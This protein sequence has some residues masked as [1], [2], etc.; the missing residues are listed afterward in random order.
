MYEGS[1][2]L[3]MNMDAEAQRRGGAHLHKAS[4]RLRMN[5]DAEALRRSVVIW[6]L[7]RRGAEEIGGDMDA[8]ALRRRGDQC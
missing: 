4:E 1:E 3:R 8:E 7:R 6:T 2:R 5:M